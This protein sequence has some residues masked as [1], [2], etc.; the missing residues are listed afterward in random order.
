MFDSIRRGSNVEKERESDRDKSFGTLY[1]IKEELGRI[2]AVNPSPEQVETAQSVIQLAG[3]LP[4]LG[5]AGMLV[6]PETDFSVLAR[7][8]A[9]AARG[10]TKADLVTHI[11][12]AIREYGSD[13]NLE[14]PTGKRSDLWEEETALPLSMQRGNEDKIFFAFHNEGVVFYQFGKKLEISND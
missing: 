11:I 2:D 12:S 9:N 13:R 7:H 3:K 14:I 8:I 10:E 4:R 1:K 6:T 5:V